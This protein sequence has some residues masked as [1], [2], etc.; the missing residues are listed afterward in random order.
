MKIKL[1]NDVTNHTCVAYDEKEIGQ[2]HD[3][4]YRYVLCRKQN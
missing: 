2:Q 1:S 3:R 4:S